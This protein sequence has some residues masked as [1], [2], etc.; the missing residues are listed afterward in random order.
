MFAFI[1]YRLSCLFYRND[2]VPTMIKRVLFIPVTAFVLCLV[3]VACNQQSEFSR[4]YQQTSPYNFV[5]TMMNLDIAISEFNYRIIHKSEIGQA[6]RDRGTEDYPLS[7]VVS[8]CNITYAHE[9]LE[10]NPD[11]ISDMPCIVAVRETSDGNVVVSTRLMDETVEDS[12]ER[13]FARKIN[14]DLKK[15]VGATVL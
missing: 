2:S 4:H 14:A 15:I 12:E 3:L 1:S 7:T 6:I 10:I 11:L 5:D 8:F 13:A 9:M